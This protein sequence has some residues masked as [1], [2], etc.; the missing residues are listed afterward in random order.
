M[1]FRF[2]DTDIVEVKIITPSI[3][4][5]G[6]GFFFEAYKRSEF[7]ENGISENFV[8][9]NVSVSHKNVVRGLHYQLNP[10]AQDKLVLVTAGSIFD[11]AVDIRKDSPTYGKY[12]SATLNADLGNMLW[13]PKGF[14]HGFM[15]LENNTRV[16]YKI[17]AEYS[18]EHERGI[19][20]NDP[21]IGIK[22]PNGTYVLNDRDS[23]FPTLSH[24]EIN[25][26]YGD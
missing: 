11:V 2:I 25:F 22:W 26:K 5:D 1:T 3:Y 18:P 12:V 24:A 8:Q 9:E 20:Y 19:L 6:R 4:H 17:T 15:A 14:A 23:H 10:F 7:T 21:E 13:I 16:S